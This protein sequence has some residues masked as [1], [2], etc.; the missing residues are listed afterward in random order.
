RENLG[1]RRLHLEALHDLQPLLPGELR[2]DRAHAGA[3]HL[4]I[5]LLR[6]VLVGQIRENLAASA[7]QWARDV[8]GAGATGALLAPRFLVRMANVAAPLLRAGAAAGVGLVGRDHLVHQRL[9]VLTPAQ[10]VG[11]RDRRR[12]LPL[13]A[14]ELELHPDPLAADAGG[15]LADWAGAGAALAG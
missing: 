2:Q 4:A 11:G 8:P 12:P 3:I 13:R 7:P 6:E 1:L 5:H 15:G 14:D 10:R 9:V